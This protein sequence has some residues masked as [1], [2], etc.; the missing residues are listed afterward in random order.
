[1]KK[2]IILKLSA[3]ASA[4]ML[5]CLVQASETIKL[6]SVHLCCNGCVKGVDK[7]VATVDG[8]TATSDKDAGTVT[9]TVPD[10]ETGQK[11]VNALVAAGYFGT[12]SDAA[13]KVRGRTGAKGAKVEKITV[14]NVHLCCDKCVKAVAKALESVDGVKGN[15]AAKNAESFEVTGSFN[16]KE[17]FTALQKAGLTGKLAKQ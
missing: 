17:V 1:M 10:K 9:L 11:A 7:A 14:T 2:S 12:T 3:F 8:V 13:I 15:T 5:G 16:D 6:E 4:F